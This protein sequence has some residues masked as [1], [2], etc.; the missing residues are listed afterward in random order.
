MFRKIFLSLSRKERSVFKIALAFFAVSAILIITSFVQRSTVVVAASGGEYRFGLVGQPAIVNPVL[1]A[2]ETD[3]TLAEM[4]FANLGQLSDAIT[5]V[6]TNVWDVHLK[7][8]IF[9]QDGAPITSE[10]IIFTINTIENP[11]ANSPLFASF[12]GVRAE[13][14]SQLEVQFTLPT[15][16]VF[17]ADD[18]LKNLGLIPEHIFSGVAPQNLTLSKYS[19]NPIGSGPYEFSD[20]QSDDAGFITQMTLKESNTYYVGHAPYIPKLVIKFYKT[21]ADAVKAFDQGQIDGLGMSTS[22]YLPQITLR[23]NT[24]FLPSNRYYAIFINQSTDPSLASASLRQ[25]LSQAIDREALVKTVLGGR[26]VP[27]YGPTSLTGAPSFSGTL[28]TSTLTGENL[29]LTVP[30]EPFLTQTAEIIKNDWEKYGASVTIKSTDEAGFVNNILRGNNYSL[31]LFGNVTKA[32]QDL[33]SFWDSSQYPYPGQNLSFYHNSRVDALLE[34]YR[35]N[36]SPTARS[37][38]LK[39]L[40]DQIANDY[41]ATFLYSPDYVYVSSPS[42]GGF[43]PKESVD[44]PSDIYSQVTDWYVNTRRVF[45]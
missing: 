36:S 9:W 6:D 26:A 31:L 40:S 29:I 20:Y 38:E 39:Q 7:Q 8:N 13:K 45:K 27:F 15:S 44:M 10:D 5:Q 35:T 41:P 37:A 25:A 17:F 11:E 4:T 28:G 30:K 23:H 14:K 21:T 43:N 16:Y 3:Q 33:Y 2:S 32:N 42:L 34:D 24:Y 22:Y 1:P 12:Q 19:L 18:H